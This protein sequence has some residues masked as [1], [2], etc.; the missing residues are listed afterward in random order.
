MTVRTACCQR[1]RVLRS[2]RSTDTSAPRRN[3]TTVPSIT[4][5]ISSGA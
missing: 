1:P 3:A 5:Q 2:I 4:I